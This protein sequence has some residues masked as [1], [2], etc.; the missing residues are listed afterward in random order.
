MN[1]LDYAWIALQPW[2]QYSARR[3]HLRAESEGAESVLVFENRLPVGFWMDRKSRM[4]PPSSWLH[5]DCHCHATQWIELAEP[6]ANIVSFHACRAATAGVP[7]SP[8]VVFI[9]HGGMRLFKG[10]QTPKPWAAA[11]PGALVPMPSLMFTS[12]EQPTSRTT[13]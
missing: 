1:I 5:T 11:A 2:A 9:P 10:Q 12:G 6:S 3:D 7:W 13:I 8:C 4:M